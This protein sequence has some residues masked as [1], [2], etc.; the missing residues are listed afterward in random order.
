VLGEHGGASEPATARAVVA[1]LPADATLVLSS[2][3]PVRDVEWY[4]APREG[5]AVVSNRG[6]NGIDGVVATAVG[7]AL[8][9]GRP[10]AVL[11]GDLAFIHDS[12]GLLG[13]DARDID[14]VCVVS[15]ND[16]GGI[17]SFLPQ[18]RSVDAKRFEQLFG[19]PHG[20]NLV[21]LAAAY[22]VAAREAD[23]VEHDV[24]SAVSAGGVHVLVVRTDRADNVAVHGRI[25]A[26]VASAAERALG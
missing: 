3:M 13:A 21:D 18:A 22:G 11:L 24:R 4:A 19:T 12:N 26:A 2:S 7:V 10:T 25:N 8:A 6:A 20:I 1:A 16:G 15:D 23:D 14:L 5:L 9:T 17:F